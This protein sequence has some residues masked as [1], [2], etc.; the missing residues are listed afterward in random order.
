M[1]MENP[2]FNLDSIASA[3]GENILTAVIQLNERIDDLASVLSA[4]EASNDFEKTQFS[5]RLKKI[6]ELQDMITKE[7]GLQRQK[8]TAIQQRLFPAGIPVTP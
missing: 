1:A 3:Y 8:L 7:L 5:H 2:Y 6:L 4:D